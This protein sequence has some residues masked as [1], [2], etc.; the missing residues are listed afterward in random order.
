MDKILTIAAREYKAAVKS[1]AFLITML[2]MPVF[3]GGSIVMQILLE[4][5][6]IK[7]TKIAIVDRSEGSALAAALLVSNKAIQ[8]NREM[9]QEELDKMPPQMREMAKVNYTFETIPPSENTPAAL[10]AQRYE[11]SQRVDKGELDGFIEIGKSIYEPIN[12]DIKKMRD[13]DHI[14]AVHFKNV[15]DSIKFQQIGQQILS[16]PVHARRLA[17]KSIRMNDVVQLLV[18]VMIEMKPLAVKNKLTGDIEEGRKGTQFVNLFLPAA[19]IGLMFMVI[20]V[21]A[22]PA[23]QGIVEE[24]SQRIAEVLLGSASPF[25]IMSGKLVGVIGVALTM[26]SVYLVGGYVVAWRYGYSE[27]LPPALLFWFIIYLILALLI[28]GSLFIA[29]GAAAVE[30]KDTQTLM[31]PIMLVACLPF[32]ALSKIMNDPN[33]IVSTVAS[34]FPFGTPMIMVARQSVPPGVPLWQMLTGVGI[35]LVTTFVCVW[36]AGRIFRVG[37]L[38]QGKGAKLSEIIK[39]VVKG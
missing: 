16:Q 21:G 11:L 22:T 3:M 27:M 24:K 36:A 7:D 18:P 26:A 10:M 6:A 15:M 33:G 9:I 30:V 38:M 37:I 32:F 1:K 12:G 4:K 28:Y 31:M 19:L 2:L 14:V 35:V 23:M 34:F 8:D 17:D 39:W 29:V 20:M 25:Q 13:D 5:I